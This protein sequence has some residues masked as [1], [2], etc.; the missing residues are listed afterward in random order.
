MIDKKYE[1]ILV[2]TENQ[3][4]KVVLNRPEKFNAISPGLGKDLTDVMPLIGS[5]EDTRAVVIIGTGRA[6]CAGGDIQ[7]DVV[8]V[9]KMRPKEWRAYIKTFCDLTRT[10][11]RL[12]KPVIA[13]ING[14]TVGGGCDIAMSCDSYIIRQGQIRLWVYQDGYYL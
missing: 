2:K 9:S 5:D 12:P 8:P 1:N 14:V 11:T 10:L 3:I 7:E 6:F 13:A 4:T